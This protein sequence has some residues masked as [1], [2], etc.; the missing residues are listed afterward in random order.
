MS[1][2]YIIEER[3]IERAMATYPDIPE[4]VEYS[5]PVVAFGYPANA[6]MV[7]VGINP[8]SVEF[9][10]K[11]KPSRVLAEGKKRLVDT[12]ILGI[13]DPSALTQEEAIQVINGCYSYFDEGNNPYD[14]FDHLNNHINKH[15]GNSYYAGTAAH[16]DL[17][18]WATDPVWGNIKDETIKVQLLKNDADFLR[19]QVNS[20]KFE[21]IYLN[22]KSVFEQL[23]SNGII[24][25]APTGKVIHFKTKSGAPRELICYQGESA[26]GSLVLGCNKPFPGHYISGEELPRVVDELRTFFDQ[27]TK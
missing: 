22:G 11:S 20:K 4:F 15:F 1:D 13:E 12:Q 8:S 18:Q 3:V 24:T 6:K 17:V 16:L 9:Q 25:A 7:T 2:K 5:T 19:Y 10:T 26:N 27:Y 21:V 14:W 23:T